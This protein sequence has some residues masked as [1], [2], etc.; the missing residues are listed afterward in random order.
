MYKKE[1]ILSIFFFIFIREKKYCSFG[2]KINYPSPNLM[3]VYNS[4]NN[5][6]YPT[7]R[8][9]QICNSSKYYS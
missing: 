3:L 5:K 6:K 8:W 2:N 4:S 7:S 1:H 9:L